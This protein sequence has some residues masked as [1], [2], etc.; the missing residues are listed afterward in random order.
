MSSVEA[1]LN[2]LVS[3]AVS[4]MGQNGQNDKT[5]KVDLRD[6]PMH[7]IKTEELPGIILKLI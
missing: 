4:R 5:V 1:D 7:M 3:E 6:I 2:E